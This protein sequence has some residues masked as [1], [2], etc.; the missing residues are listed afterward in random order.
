MTIN[1]VIVSNNAVPNY[2]APR[3]M[4]KKEAWVKQTKICVHWQIAKSIR[5]VSWDTK[6]ANNLI[7]SW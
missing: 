2:F 5:A 3:N 7:I 6:I 1:S 4:L